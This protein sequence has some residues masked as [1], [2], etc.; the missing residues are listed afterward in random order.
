MLFRRSLYT[1]SVKQFEHYHDYDVVLTSGTYLVEGSVSLIGVVSGDVV[2]QPNGSHGYETV[3]E[4]VQIVPLVLDD[5]EYCGWNEEDEDDDDA[6]DDAQMDESDVDEL[7]EVAEAVTQGL[8]H[9]A[10]QQ[11]EPLHQRREHDQ[12]QR[13]A[14]SG[15]HDTEDLTA[16]RQRRHMAIS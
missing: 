1:M 4:R 7:V 15:V 3:I 12:R 13:D 10:R 14:Y 16:L 11:H 8:Q 9:E 6:D 2:P 5:G